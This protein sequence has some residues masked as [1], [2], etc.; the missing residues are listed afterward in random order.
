ML[1]TAAAAAVVQPAGTR[2]VDYAALDAAGTQQTAAELKIEGIRSGPARSNVDIAIEAVPTVDHVSLALGNYCSAYKLW[3]PVSIMMT[4]VAL[5]ADRDGVAGAP[6]GQPLLLLN[7]QSARSYRRCVE[8]AEYN[9]RCITR[10]TLGGEAVQ[11]R[12]D[13]TET[14]TPVSAQV[15]RDS[16]VGGFCGGVSRALGAISREAG[17]QLLDA[18]LKAST[19]TAS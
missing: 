5:E 8:V 2:A 17:Q 9:V 4:S 13:G 19:A 16:S 6:D 1:A 14:R 18:A 15:E 11:R 12:V 3:N 10:V 7:L